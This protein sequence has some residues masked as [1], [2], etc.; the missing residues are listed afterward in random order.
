MVPGDIGS[1][2][3]AEDTDRD[4]T[5]RR[6]AGRQ[7]C[8]R[9]GELFFRRFLRALFNLPALDTGILKQAFHAIVWP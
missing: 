7:F 5:S 6:E 2:D 8:V 4:R 9:S 3:I 1:I